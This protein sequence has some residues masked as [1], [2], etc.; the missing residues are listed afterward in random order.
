MSA[1]EQQISPL[2]FFFFLPFL[3]IFNDRS[4]LKRISYSDNNNKRGCGVG[5]KKKKQKRKFRKKRLTKTKR[6][7]ISNKKAYKRRKIQKCR[8][9]FLFSLS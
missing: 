3:E 2:F 7:G 8:R 4:V 1:I 5:A 9:F 6:L